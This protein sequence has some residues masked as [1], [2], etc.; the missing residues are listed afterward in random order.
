MSILGKLR[1]LAR[2]LL[3]TPLF[4]I[5]CLRMTELE[6]ERRI[7]VEFEGGL[8][9]SRCFERFVS[10]FGQESRFSVPASFQ[11]AIGRAAVK[12]GRQ[13]TAQAARNAALRAV[14]P[15]A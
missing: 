7:C 12:A 2:F 8:E 3:L 14:S 9:E 1:R 10:Q 15:M 6:E 13:A 11:P 4:A 5:D